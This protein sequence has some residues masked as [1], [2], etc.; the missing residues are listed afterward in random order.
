M[1]L[2]RLALAVL[3]LVVAS[4][5]EPT[6]HRL[7]TSFPRL[8]QG[9]VRVFEEYGHRQTTASRSHRIRVGDGVRDLV[10]RLDCVGVEGK[11]DVEITGVGGGG[12]DCHATGG[13]RGLVILGL[14]PHGAGTTHGRD[15]DMTVLAPRGSRWS[16]AVDTSRLSQPSS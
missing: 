14:R 9:D 1:R 7:A 6:P 13:G 2:R 4:C 8:R 11:L 12:M 10:F 15:H 5:S 3:L 16:V